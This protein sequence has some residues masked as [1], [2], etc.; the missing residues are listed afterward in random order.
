MTSALFIA[1]HGFNDARL[2]G[3]RKTAKAAALTVPP[4]LL[5]RADRVTE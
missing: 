4:T 1:G 2:T 5:T 3:N